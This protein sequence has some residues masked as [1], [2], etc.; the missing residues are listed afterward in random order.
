MWVI[1]TQNG[2]SYCDKAKE[3]LLEKEQVYFTYNLRHNSNKWVLAL[4]RKANLTTV[5]QVFTPDGSLVGGYTEL[6][7][8]LTESPL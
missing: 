6:K 4:M 3:L 7:E 8:L 5:P 1:I 2:C